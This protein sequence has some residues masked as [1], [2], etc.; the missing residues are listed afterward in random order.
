MLCDIDPVTKNIDTEKLESL[1]NAKT[2]VIIPVHYCGYPCEM[3]TITEIAS[4]YSLYIVEDCAHAIESLYK[5]Q[6]CGTFG[7]IG[8]FSFYATKNIAIGEGGMAVSKSES[9]IQRIS[10]LGLHGLSRDAWRRFERSNKKVYDVTEV[11]YKMNMTDIQ[12]SI[13]IEQ[14]KRIDEMY[15]RRKEIWE[16]YNS[17]LQDTNVELPSLPPNI[18]STL[19]TYIQ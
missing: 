3:D 13:G 18:A 14:L 6:H 12:S 2:K 17:Y 19:D 1:V 11:G 7:E 10:K 9:L 8:C 5:N 16:M 15:E 4:K